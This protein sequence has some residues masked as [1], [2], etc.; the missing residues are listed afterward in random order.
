MVDLTLLEL[1]IVEHVPQ[2]KA[3]AVKQ[4]YPMPKKGFHIS[5]AKATQF[6]KGVEEMRIFLK[7]R[8]FQGFIAAIAL[9]GDVNE[10]GAVFGG[11]QTVPTEVTKKLSR[12]LKRAFL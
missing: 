4:L 3:E 9:I 2:D 6:W 10:D 5:K 1:T 11:N 7:M 8:A 12:F